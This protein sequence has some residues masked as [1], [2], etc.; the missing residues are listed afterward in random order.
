[1][2]FHVHQIL[3]LE[4]LELGETFFQL[5]T[6]S[7]PVLSQNVSQTNSVWTA[8]EKFKSIKQKFDSY[9]LYQ[10]PCVPCSY[11]GRLLYPQKA[12]WIQRREN[13]EY[14]L[15]QA[16][17]NLRLVINPNPPEDQIGSM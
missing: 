4:P 13:F 2:S 8:S 16:Y 1:M 14:P 5:S 12:N 7:N 6:H 15:T 10:H 3:E 11:C 9:I 17:P